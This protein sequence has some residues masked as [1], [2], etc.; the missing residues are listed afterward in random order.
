MSH[1]LKTIIYNLDTYSVIKS[2]TETHKT[3]EIYNNTTNLP[4]KV[5]D[6]KLK[7]ITW[8]EG[9][10]ISLCVFMSFVVSSLTNLFGFKITTCLNTRE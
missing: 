5:T 1:A 3:P 7:N 8:S 2:N 10:R 9:M 4:N 6:K